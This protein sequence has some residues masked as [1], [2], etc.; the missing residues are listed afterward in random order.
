MEKANSGDR[1]A[2]KVIPVA[3]AAGGL[4]QARYFHLVV[5]DEKALSDINGVFGGV[6]GLVNNAGIIARKSFAEEIVSGS[7]NLVTRR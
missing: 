1:L 4:G 6:H 2:N 7:R 3:G 5:T